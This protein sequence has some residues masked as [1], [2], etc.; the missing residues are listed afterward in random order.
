[1]KAIILLLFFRGL[2]KN[3]TTQAFFHHFNH[4]AW[5]NRELLAFS[6]TQITKNCM[7]QK[8]NSSLR[9]NL[10]FLVFGFGISVLT[11]KMTR[12]LS[13]LLKRADNRSKVVNTCIH[14]LWSI[15][16]GCSPW[17]GAAVR[18]EIRVSICVQLSSDD[19]KKM[20]KLDV[21]LSF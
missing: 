4:H 15:F 21:Y 5:Y 18:A 6:S 11:H 2:I 3:G 13:S 17:F 14:V 7:S 10:V 19:S 8:Q 9:L 12:S 20:R 1:M 16:S